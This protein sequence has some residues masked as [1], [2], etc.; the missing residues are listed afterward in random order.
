MNEWKKNEER[1]ERTKEIMTVSPLYKC[2]ECL[3]IC[4]YPCSQMLKSWFSS[5]HSSCVHS[6]SSSSVSSQ[7]HCVQK[8]ITDSSN[9][10][11]TSPYLVHYLSEE[12]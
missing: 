8:V 9:V 7:S 10:K 11:I 4:P 5:L 2:A 3:N 1:V 12:T 6:Y